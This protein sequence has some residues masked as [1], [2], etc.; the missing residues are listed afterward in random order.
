VRERFAREMGWLSSIYGSALTAAAAIFAISR[1]V[2]DC[3]EDSDG[4]HHKAGSYDD[5]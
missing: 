4:D 2:R 5:K 1:A 3:H